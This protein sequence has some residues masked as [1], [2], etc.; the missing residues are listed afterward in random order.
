[1]TN[2]ASPSLAITN[3]TG[4]GGTN[5]TF[6]LSNS[7]ADAY[8]VEVS[9]DLMNWQLLGPATPRFLFTGTN[10]PAAPQRYYRLRYA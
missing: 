8:S 9:T 7:V 4:L 10:A 1:M 6:A 3:V 2:H 5:V